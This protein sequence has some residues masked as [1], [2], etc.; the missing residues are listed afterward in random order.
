MLTYVYETLPRAGKKMRRYEIQQSIKDAP[1]KKHPETG[2]PIRRCVVLGADP[3]VRAATIE[4]PEPRSTKRSRKQ[5]EHHAHHHHD[6]DHH[7][8]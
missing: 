2:E 8:H 1:L 4:R 3:F 6:H 5:D 7:H